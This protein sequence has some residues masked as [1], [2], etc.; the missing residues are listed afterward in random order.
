MLITL[1]VSECACSSIINYSAVFFNRRNWIEK[2][3][4]I[5]HLFK[6]S[7]YHTYYHWVILAEGAN[8]TTSDV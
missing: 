2:D 8:S 6:I 5:V 3:K 7:F 1:R 4:V